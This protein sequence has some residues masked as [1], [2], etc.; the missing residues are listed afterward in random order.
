VFGALAGVG[1]MA[2]SYWADV[3][4]GPSVAL[5]ACLLALVAALRPGAGDA[6]VR[7]GPIEGLAGG[8]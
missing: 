7:R 6:A 5:V 8:R 2:L 4:A 3:A 1:G